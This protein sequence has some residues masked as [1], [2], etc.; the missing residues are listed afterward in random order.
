MA[1]GPRVT[2]L[3]LFFALASTKIIQSDEIA[4]QVK[5]NQQLLLARGEMIW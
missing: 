3:L 5:A 1:F 2:L 4:L